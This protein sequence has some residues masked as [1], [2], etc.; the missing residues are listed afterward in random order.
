MIKETPILIEE[1]LFEFAHQ[2]GILIGICD[3]ERLTL[4]Y[5][6][7]DVPFATGDIDMRTNPKLFFESAESIIVFAVPYETSEY[8]QSTNDKLYGK[9]AIGT[10]GIDY[11]IRLKHIL[12][13]CVELIREITPINYKLHIDTGPLIEREFAKK[14]GLGFIGKNSMLINSTQGSYFNIGVLL[15]DIPLNST[16]IYCGDTC[17]D[18]TLCEKACVGGAINQGKF[19]Y[20]RCVSYLTQKKEELSKDENLHGFIYGCDICQK[21]CPFNKFK[22][23]SNDMIQI[24]EFLGLSNRQFQDLYGKTSIAWRG[25]K[26][27][28]RN[29]EV[30]KNAKYKRA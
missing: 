26:V 29:A 1:T 4:D 24:D 7:G 3:A 22:D 17:G 30:I 15:V 23:L 27:L 21:V 19:D 9:L 2:K 10:S 13:E 18:C 8:K 5:E 12:L 28:Q 25:K 14:A 6:T 20:K 11:H 16:P